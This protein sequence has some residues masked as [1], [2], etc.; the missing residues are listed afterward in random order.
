LI[1]EAPPVTTP[2]RHYHGPRALRD[3]AEPLRSAG[4]LPAPFL[5][6]EP[7][8]LAEGFEGDDPGAHV[9]YADNRPTAYMPWVVR[10]AHFAVAVGPGVV[11]RPP[12]RQLRVFGCLAAE[13]QASPT[14][15]M[16][17]DCLRE[18]PKWHVARLFELPA[19]S[20]LAR[21][22]DRLAVESRRGYHVSIDEFKTLQVTLARDF[23][24][25]LK[26][27]FSRKTRYNLKREVRLL[28]E[29]APG[30][31]EVAIYTAPDRVS[32][33]LRDVWTIGKLAYQWRL[34]LSRVAKIPRLADRLTE[35]ARRGQLRGY[36]L[37]VRGAPAAYCLTTVRGTGLS[38][39]DVGYDPSLAALHPGKVLL[40]R[41]LEDLHATRVVDELEFGRGGAGY[42]ILFANSSR[43]AINGS[44]YAPTGYGRMLRALVATAD[45][46]Y[47]RLRPAL[48]PVM[49]YVKRT[50]RGA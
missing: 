11:L 2:I 21:C 20:E 46:A 12:S 39:D 5:G 47:R 25:Y 15:E 29:A 45:S 23:E 18:A 48:R 33:F 41:I 44:I 3:I 1:I 35:L 50:F 9:A 31:V 36:V 24:S 22:V 32:E 10:R 26:E 17:L 7:T 19:A 37:R 4:L 43:R 6:M 38:Y 14:F 42:K 28:D 30:Q 40:Y 8:F 34:G 16:L 13:G 27:Q 49:P